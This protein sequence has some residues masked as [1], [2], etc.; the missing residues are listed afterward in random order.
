MSV[1]MAG[2]MAAA[3]LVLTAALAA[4]AAITAAHRARAAADL[5]ALA[6]ASRVAQG[7]TPT[8]ACA[9]AGVM[10]RANRAQLVACVSLRDGSVEVTVSC[11]W[12]AKVPGFEPGA[13]LARSRAGQGW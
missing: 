5:A 1:L 8:A 11:R 9:W 6:A 4:T 10:A 12:S 7:A 13:A 3:V 2:V